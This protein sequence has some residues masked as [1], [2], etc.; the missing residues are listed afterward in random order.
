MVIQC[1]MSYMKCNPLQW[2]ENCTFIKKTYKY[3]LDGNSVRILFLS[4]IP[5]LLMKPV[6]GDW[7]TTHSIENAESLLGFK[8]IQGESGFHISNDSQ[9]KNETDYNPLPNSLLV[10]CPNLLVSAVWIELGQQNVERMLESKRN[11]GRED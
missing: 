3:C 8:T 9:L 6:S 7:Q 1:R 4:Q 10:P 2:L 11:E 5:L